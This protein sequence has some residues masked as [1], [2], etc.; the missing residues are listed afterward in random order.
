MAVKEVALVLE[1]ERKTVDCGALQRF[2]LTPRE[3]EVLHWV[4]EGKTN[5][6]IG[7]ILHATPRTVDKHLERIYA[8]LRVNTRMAAA[9]YARTHA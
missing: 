6:R 3:A 4:T 2:G 1:E 8:K 7:V 5:R 9:V